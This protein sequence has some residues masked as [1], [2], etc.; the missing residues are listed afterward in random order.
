VSICVA[1]PAYVTDGTA[2]G[3]A[4]G[5][6]QCRWFGGMVGNHVADIV[7]R[8]GADGAAVPQALSDYIAAREGYDYNQH[9]KAGN[10]HATF[11]PD[12]VIDRFCL[13]GPVETQV[14]RLRELEALGVDQFA[15]YLQHDAKSA[16][17]QSYGDH[18]LP[19]VNVRKIAKA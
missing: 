1:A 3:L 6:D 11:V 5:R 4:H 17:L 16:T 9:G 12:E 15:L 8:Y 19:Q 7:A 2:A 18:V 13:I 10:T 14:A